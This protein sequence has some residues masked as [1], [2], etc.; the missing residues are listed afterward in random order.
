MVGRGLVR[1]EEPP[2]NLRTV[3]DGFGQ[4]YILHL[5]ADPADPN[6]LFAVTGN[7]RIL[8]STDQGKNWAAFGGSG[9]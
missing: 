5:A 4:D 1:A 9:S 2:L 8:A 3:G 7:G 6:R